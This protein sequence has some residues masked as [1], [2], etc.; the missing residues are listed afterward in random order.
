M[1]HHLATLALLA[2]S[3]TASAQVGQQAKLDVVEWYNSP[4]ISAEQLRGHTV[5]VEVFRTW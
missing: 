1:K 5:M 2:L 3:A 4:P